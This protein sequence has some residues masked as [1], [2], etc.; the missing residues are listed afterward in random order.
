MNEI[1]ELIKLY[2]EE[3]KHT[4]YQ[5]LPTRLQKYFGNRIDTHSRYE[6]ERLTYILDKIDVNSKTILDIGGNTGYFSFELLS[7]GAKSIDYYEGN[8]NHA[9]FTYLAS[10]ILGEENKIVV[11]D[12]YYNFQEGNNKKY[13]VI[14]LLNVLHHV[15]D[16]YGDNNLSL[17][18]AKNEIIDSLQ[19]ISTQTTFLVFQLGFNW[20]GNRNLCLFEKGTKKEMLDFIQSGVKGYWDI[21]NIGI[22]VKYSGKII[23]TD[24]DDTNIQRNDELGEFLNRPLIIMKSKANYK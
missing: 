9:K 1:E 10:K 23:Y 4:Q 17:E 7:H 6:S 21:I 3:G 20:K 14:L 2:S 13:D 5:I 24:L 15:G 16:D 22:P 18:N 11:T 12:E 19:K 8:K